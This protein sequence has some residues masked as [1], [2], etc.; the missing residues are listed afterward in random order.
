MSIINRRKFFGTA[1]AALAA[2]AGASLL[3]SPFFPKTGLAARL[4]QAILDGDGKA[5]AGDAFSV[6]KHPIFIITA[7]AK[8]ESAGWLSRPNQQSVGI[9]GNP[10]TAPSAAYAMHGFTKQFGDYLQPL[11]GKIAFGIIPATTTSGNH[12]Y[13]GLRLTMDKTGCLPA[14]VNEANGG[15]MSLY[16]ASVGTA[17][18]STACF[19]KGGSQLITY[20]TLD[21]AV[22][23]VLN[24]LDPLKNLPPASQTV[25]SRLNSRVTSDANFRGGL[26]QLATRL[27]SAKAP[28]AAARTLAGQT[29]MALPAGTAAPDAL[30]SNNPL[31]P[32]IEAAAPLINLGLMHA[33]VISIANSDPNNGGDHAARGGNNVA[34]GARSPNEVKSC[35]AQALVRIFELFPEA[36]VSLVSDGGRGPTGG[37]SQNFEGWIAGPEAIVKNSFINSASRDDSA[38]FGSTPMPV[39]LSGGTNMAP[40]ESHIMSTVARAA[41]LTMNDYPYIPGL[42]VKG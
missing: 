38:K 7:H 28:L 24:A 25:L 27:E 40:N 11:A 9:V 5:L 26:E 37:D 13:D 34:F 12:V 15:L 31:L 42:L 21:S 33:T 14:F 35:V 17:D 2:Q 8:W 19:G 20:S 29:P 39:A 23:S 16:F 36:I 32:Q 10:D 18:G 22:G 6:A 30:K 41:G 3:T 1:S 4:R